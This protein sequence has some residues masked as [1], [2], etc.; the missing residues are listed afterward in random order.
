MVQIARS[1]KPVFSQRRFPL[2]A[3]FRNDK[4]NLFVIQGLLILWCSPEDTEVKLRRVHYSY[5]IIYLCLRLFSF[6]KPPPVYANVSLNT[7]FTW[8]EYKSAPIRGKLESFPFSCVPPM[9]LCSIYCS[10]SLYS[11]KPNK[12]LHSYRKL[13]R[14]SREAVLIFF[15]VATRKLFLVSCLH[16]TSRLLLCPKKSCYYYNSRFV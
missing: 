2:H 9:C 3:Q 5:N 10:S 7:F 4:L 1:I 13:L 14:Y 16:S 8:D 15:Y 6:A 12:N 11:K